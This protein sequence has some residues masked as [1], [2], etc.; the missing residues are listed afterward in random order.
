MLRPE[1]AALLA[2][3]DLRFD[4]MLAT[5]ALD[6]VRALVAAGLDPKLPAMGALGVAPLAAHLR[7]DLPLD[8]AIARA[9]LDTRQYVKRQ[10]T[11]L[12][13]NMITWNEVQTIDLE[14]N[15]RSMSM[16]I[17]NATIPD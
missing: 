4:R 13:R 2:R 10:I 8:A 1:R 15:D 7:G 14:R 16:F 11:W 5:G 6:E 17:D 9:K 3:A 12:K